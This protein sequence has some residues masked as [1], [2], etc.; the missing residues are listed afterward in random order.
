MKIKLIR[1]LIDQK[2]AESRELRPE[3]NR[4]LPVLPKKTGRK[5]YDRMQYEKKGVQ[6]MLEPI[7]EF[8]MHEF[9]LGYKKA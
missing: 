8:L 5:K 7:A 9:I 4:V 2:Y 1:N 6:P 3:K